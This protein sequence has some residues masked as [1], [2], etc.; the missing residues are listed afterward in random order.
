MN[1]LVV[2]GGHLGRRIAEHLDRKGHEVSIIE[3]NESKLALLDPKFGGITFNTFPMDVNNLIG[4]GIKNCDALTVTTSDDNLNITV[5]QI[6]KNIFGIK[7]VVSRISDPYREHV[8]ETLGLKTVC[9]TNMAA[10]SIIT[11]LTDPHKP[12]NIIF[13]TTMLG[14]E[15][16]ALERKKIGR[17]LIDISDENGGVIIGVM[18]ADDTVILNSSA[19]NVILGRGDRLI[20]STKID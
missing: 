12:K 11:A 18:R 15:L 13:G 16:V 1:I 7:N 19:K 14:F 10:D 2:G 5:S 8:F 6:A 4:A 20:I 17:R 9:P 3:E